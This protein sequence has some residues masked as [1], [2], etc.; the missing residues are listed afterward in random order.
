MHYLNDCLFTIIGL[1]S[2]LDRK[3][4]KKRFEKRLKDV[5]GME[6]IKTK[7][8]KLAIRVINNRIKQEEEPLNILF[9]GPPQLCKVTVR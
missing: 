7:V 3:I 5:I 9:Y 8:N 2:E 1:F 4:I 6:S